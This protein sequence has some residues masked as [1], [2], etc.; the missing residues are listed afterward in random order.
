MGIEIDF[1]KLNRIEDFIELANKKQGIS[2]TVKLCEV[3]VIQKVHPE[4]TEDMDREINMYV[5]FGDF[6]FVVDS[7][8]KTISKSYVYGSKEASGDISA[9]NRSV[10]NDRLKMDYKRLKGAGIEVEEVYF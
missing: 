5:M 9:V 1:D 3:P 2:V 6:S 7:A 10:A 8:K 4:Q